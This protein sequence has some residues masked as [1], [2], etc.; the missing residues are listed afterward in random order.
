MFVTKIGVG[1]VKIIYASIL[2]WNLGT[3][4]VSDPNLWLS[5]PIVRTGDYLLNPVLALSPTTPP[6]TA[7]P[8]H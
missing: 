5:L 8:N 7:T 3:V 2:T 1:I 6:L 4:P